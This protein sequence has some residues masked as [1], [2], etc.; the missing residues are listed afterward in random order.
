MSSSPLSSL[1]PEQL[2]VL[3]K[4][5]EKTL[6]QRITENRLAHYRPYEK[7]RDFHDAGALKRERLFM[8]GNQLGKTWAGAF[9][10][11]MH[12]TGRYPEWWRGRRFEKPVIAWAAGVTSVSTRDTVQ[13]LLLGRPGQHGTGTIPKVCIKDVQSAR[14]TPDLA[15]HIVVKHVSGGDSYIYLKSYEQGREKWQG[16]TV[17]LVWFD[18]EPPE[19]I[20]T[21]GLTR[22]NATGGFVWMTFTPL[23]GMSDVVGRFLMQPDNADISVTSMTIDDVAHY[24]AE[25]K[26][27]I[28]ASY[29]PHEREARAK[30]IPTMGSGRVFPIEESA[31]SVAPFAVPDDWLQLGAMDFG[32]DHPFAAVKLAWDRDADCIYVTNAFRKSEATPVIHA[33]ALKPWGEGPANTQWLP[34]AWPHDGH[35]H[36]KGSGDQ[37]A[38]LYKK[39]GLRMHHDHATHKAGGFGTEAGITDMLERMETGRFKVFASLGEWFEEFRLYHRKDGLIVKLRDDLMS[40]TRIGVMML[41]IARKPERKRYDAPRTDYLDEAW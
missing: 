10:A 19:A 36:D 18:E 1:P 26:A 23:K 41:R 2:S 29:P 16:E 32:Y 11:A 25:D 33:G 39:Q 14:G 12:A 37:L 40:A 20:Y 4:T 28:I 27:R 22:T 6:Q 35:Q 5:A 30:G 15:D 24:S 38:A 34:W 3:L 21:E 31:I 13:R 7:Q 17:D 8:A 9:E